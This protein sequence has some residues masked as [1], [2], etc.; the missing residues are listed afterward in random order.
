M[1]KMVLSTFNLYW[2]NLFLINSL[3]AF[4][5]VLIAMFMDYYLLLV[6]CPLCILQRYVFVGIGLLSFFVFIFPK[7][8]KTL[9]TLIVVTSLLGIF[10]AVRQIY[11]QQLSQEE[12]L[13][14]SGCGMPLNALVEYF[15]F[16]E[17]IKL[18]V[19]GGPSCAAE[20]WRFLFNF[21]EWALIFFSGFL[22]INVTALIKSYN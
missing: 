21:A 13:A 10:F 6:A 11:L 20:D 22:G 4:G 2:R 8:K 1:K 15:G 18:A 9:V 17:G 3:G 19:M 5:I 14:L 7:I 12:L 16:F